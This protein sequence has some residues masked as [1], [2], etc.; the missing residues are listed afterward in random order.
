ML[1][2]IIMIMGMFDFLPFIQT[3]CEAHTL[4]IAA[5]PLSVVF[6]LLVTKRYWARIPYRIT[7]LYE[8]KPTRRN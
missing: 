4:L 3:V 8:G 6:M 5:F 7:C 2:H 1:N